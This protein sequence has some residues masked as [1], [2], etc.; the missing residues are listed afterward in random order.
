MSG[1]HILGKEI[2]DII[3]DVRSVLEDSLK[4]MPDQ[5]MPPQDIR[6]GLRKRGV[7]G[8]EIEKSGLKTNLDAGGPSISPRLILDD[9]QRTRQDKYS[10]HTIRGTSRSPA[11]KLDNV[12]ALA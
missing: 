11:T 2:P 7:Q 12:K 6:N 8:F 4:A 3:V 9:L 5:K 1:L 10:V